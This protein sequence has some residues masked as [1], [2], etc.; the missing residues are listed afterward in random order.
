MHETPKKHWENL[1]HKKCPIC[2]EK[3]EWKSHTFFC[4]NH[5]ENPFIINSDKLAKF[6]LNKNG[7]T[8]KNMTDHERDILEDAIRS[9][10][11]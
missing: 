6:L 10:S 5:R 7:P 2:N 9:F 11:K 1:I 8:F 3:L 4:N